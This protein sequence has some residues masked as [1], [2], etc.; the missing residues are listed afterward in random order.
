[1]KHL[2]V[3]GA[4]AIVCAMVGFLLVAQVR[5]TEGLRDRLATEREED[6]ARILAGLSR[7]SDRL[8][9]ELTE[10]RLTLAALQSS[11]QSDELALATL[12]QRLDDLRI[13][14]GVVPAV[15]EGIGLVVADP[16]RLLGQDQLV[17]TVQ[18][19][20]DAG[21]EAIAVNGV[22]LIA[23]SAFSTAQGAQG[24]QVEAQVEAQEGARGGL[25]VDGRPLEVPY[26]ITAIGP[27]ETMAKA[28]GIPGGAVDA[29]ESVPR[30]AVAMQLEDRLEVP[31]RPS[32]QGLRY[33][34]PAPTPSLGDEE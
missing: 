15:G 7:E 33:G 4:T 3:R 16:D 32:A 14:A 11:A 29:L 13:L 1:M 5:T 22:R 18:E 34:R 17:D 8:Q 25:L 26:R 24:A 27:A 2:W 6:L 28:L 9:S 10:G 21:A 30:V 12:Q 23:S 31:A 20:R 19:L